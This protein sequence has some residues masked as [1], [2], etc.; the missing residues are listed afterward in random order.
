MTSSPQFMVAAPSSNSGKT[1]VTLGLLRAFQR[2]GRSVQPFKCGP[3]YLDTTHHTLAAGQQGINLDLFMSSPN[4]VKYLY[5]KHCENKETVV[6]ESVMGLYDG[7]VDDRGSSASIAKL[8]QLPVILVVDARAMAYSAGAL[9]YGFKHFDPEVNLVGVIFNFVRSAS[10]Y[11]FLCDACR[12]INVT[13]LGY[14]PPEENIKIPSRYLGLSIERTINFDRIIDQTADH[15]E[16]HLDLDQLAEIT[17]RP[18]PG[19]PGQHDSTAINAGKVIAIARDEAFRFT[20]YENIETFK[21]LGRVIYFSPMH[22]TALP[23]ADVI[24]LAGGYPELYVQTLAK[25]KDMLHAIRKYCSQ[26]GHLLAECGGFMYLGHEI[27]DAEGQAHAMVNFFPSTASMAD[28]KLTLGYRTFSWE[29]TTLK[30]HEFHY[31]TLYGDGKLPSIGTLLNAKQEPAGSKVYRKGNVIAS[32]I[33]FY[34]A[35]QEGFLQQFILSQS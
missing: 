26:G 33:H 2:K 21:R 24:Y 8:L 27:I 12:K 23:K 29:Q 28:K 5:Q 9:V 18:L 7:A 4:H 15:L 17:S 6:V 13:A 10:H 11:R 34:W 22:D 14:L 16:K 35:E 25:N 19:R 20:Y 3:D 32:Y 1:T 31:S 30:G